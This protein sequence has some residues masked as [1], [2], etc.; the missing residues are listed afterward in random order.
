MEFMSK[1]LLS[2]RRF[3]PPTISS[4]PQIEPQDPIPETLCEKVIDLWSNNVSE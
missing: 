4:N 2:V 1:F 3:N